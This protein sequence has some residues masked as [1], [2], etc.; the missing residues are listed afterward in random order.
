MPELKWPEAKSELGRL[1]QRVFH[2]A[3]TAADATGITVRS[4]RNY[5]AGGGKT[6]RTIQERMK[7]AEWLIKQAKLLDLQDIPTKAQLLPDLFGEQDPEKKGE[8]SNLPQHTVCPTKEYESTW[9][10]GIITHRGAVTSGTR[11]ITG[12]RGQYD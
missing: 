1:R 8:G 7:Y 11:I 4:I 12:T 2:S 9:N 3:A 5:E 6:A 10:R